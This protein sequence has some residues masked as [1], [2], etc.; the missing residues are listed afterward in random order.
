VPWRTI[1][2]GQTMKANGDGDDRHGG[3]LAT[4]WALIPL[5]FMRL[6]LVN[7]SGTPLLPPPRGTSS[8]RHQDTGSKTSMPIPK[9]LIKANKCGIRRPISN[10]CVDCFG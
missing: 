1:E 8:T 6:S 9:A 2:V 7:T 3:V 10:L 5:R 4:I